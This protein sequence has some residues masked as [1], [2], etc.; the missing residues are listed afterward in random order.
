MDFGR[1]TSLGKRFAAV[2]GFPLHSLAALATEGVLPLSVEANAA[3]VPWFFGV[4]V[5]FQQLLSD[6]AVAGAEAE[7]V[8]AL[9]TLV[10]TDLG[11]GLGP[12]TKFLPAVPG[13]LTGSERLVLGQLLVL[14]AISQLYVEGDVGVGSVGGVRAV[15]SDGDMRS[16]GLLHG[17]INLAA[18]VVVLPAA[19]AAA[20]RL[21]ASA[22]LYLQ[23]R[24]T[25]T[26][27][28][29]VA[30]AAVAASALQGPTVSSWLARA[31][32]PARDVA[33]VAA[34][35]TEAARPAY[36]RRMQDAIARWQ[37]FCTTALTLQR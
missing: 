34:L 1:L 33:T 8:V 14:D 9:A 36:T 31:G 26:G 28:T 20:Q 11:S 16:H 5:R 19:A 35:A 17:L 18:A 3:L 10:V 23:A 7:A 21:C 15:L 37:T 25:A 4:N 12:A 32:T 30:A 13:S 6:A 2:A 22:S 24:E 29:A 27:T